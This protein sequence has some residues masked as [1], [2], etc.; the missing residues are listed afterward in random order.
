MLC[1]E[2][3]FHTQE[4]LMFVILTNCALHNMDISYQNIVY[5]IKH[6]Q[7]IRAKCI[8]NEYKATSL[9]NK[10]NTAHYRTI[11]YNCITIPILKSTCPF[12]TFS[13]FPLYLTYQT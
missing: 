10:N 7:Y 1:K 2:N 5:T 4:N 3:Q 6:I 12:L 13:S 8:K 11:L 9:H